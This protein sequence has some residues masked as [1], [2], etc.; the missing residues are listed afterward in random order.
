[1]TAVSSEALAGIT[2]GPPESPLQE[3]LLVPSEYPAQSIDLWSCVIR[4]WLFSP[5][6]HFE[7]LMQSASLI[8]GAST[9][10]KILG[11]KDE[12]VRNSY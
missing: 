9:Y 1:M 12:S 4:G 5:E 7:L 2:K 10:C 8:N 11:N 6:G 3:S